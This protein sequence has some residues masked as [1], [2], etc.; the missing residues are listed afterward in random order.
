MTRLY[1]ILLAIILAPVAAFSSY[2]TRGE[3]RAFLEGRRM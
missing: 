1:C 3:T 2:G